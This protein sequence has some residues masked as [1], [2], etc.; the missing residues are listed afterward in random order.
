MSQVLVSYILRRIAKVADVNPSDINTS[1]LNG[2]IEL[3]NLSISEDVL[4][5][6]PIDVSIEVIPSVFIKLP[7]PTALSSPITVKVCG[8]HV[9]VRLHTL[10]MS[11]KKNTS[12]WEALAEEVLFPDDRCTAEKQVFSSFCSDSGGVYSTV[13]NEWMMEEGSSSSSEK[14]DGSES[15]IKSHAS[16]GSS[17]L[18]DLDLASCQSDVDSEKTASFTSLNEPSSTTLDEIPP[19]ES[20]GM[21]SYFK[22]KTY[23]LVERMMDR[24]FEISFENT[25]VEII[26]DERLSVACVGSIRSVSLVVEPSSM[27][28]GESMRPMQVTILDSLVTVFFGSQKATILRMEKLDANAALVVV[29][30]TRVPFRLNSSVTVNEVIV[31][32]D[33]GNVE[34]LAK[35]VE[36]MQN[37]LTIPAYCY[38]HLHF[39]KNPSWWPYTFSC[40]QSYLEDVRKRYNF[41]S[42]HIRFY[43]NSRRRYL[44]L[45]GECYQDGSIGRRR[46]DLEELE[47]D[48]RFPD[49]IYFLRQLLQ[50]KYGASNTPPNFTGIG[51]VRRRSLH[52]FN[53]CDPYSASNPDSVVSSLERDQKSSSSS[54][55]SRKV[56]LLTHIDVLATRVK[57]PHRSAV[58]VHQVH[59]ASRVDESSLEVGD[60][61]FESGDAPPSSA[62][63]SRTEEVL[64][65]VEM[66]TSDTNLV[67]KVKFQPMCIH[68][69]FSVLRTTIVPLLDIIVQ[70][71]VLVALD[72]MPFFRSHS[73]ETEKLAELPSI[74]AKGCG[75]VQLKNYFQAT[76]AHVDPSTL[77]THAT[78]KE[79]K[80]LK[81]LFIVIPSL[82]IKVENFLA[83]LRKASFTIQE[84]REQL[85][86]QFGIN[87][88]ELSIACDEP[89][90]SPLSSVPSPSEAFLLHPISVHMESDDSI[91]CSS[92][93]FEINS[94]VW[95]SILVIC[96]CYM[97]IVP[98]EFFLWRQKRK[99]SSTPT[100]V[101]NPSIVAPS[102]LELSG[103]STR[104]WKKPK[105]AQI[106]AIEELIVSFELLDVVARTGK[107]EIFPVVNDS[108]GVSD[109]KSQDFMNLSIISSEKK[110]LWKTENEGGY[111]WSVAV[112]GMNITI[113]HKEHFSIT[114]CIGDTF[115]PRYS[116]TTVNPTNLVTAGSGEHKQSGLPNHFSKGS[117]AKH[118]RLLFLP[119]HLFC[120]DIWDIVAI[121]N[122][123]AFSSPFQLASLPQLRVRTFGQDV[124][125]KVKEAVI[126]EGVTV[127][128]FWLAVHGE[129]LAYY[130]RPYIASSLWIQSR[131]VEIDLKKMGGFVLDPLILLA[132]H[133]DSVFSSGE[134]VTNRTYN[135]FYS[136]FSHAI[137]T[138]DVKDCPIILSDSAKL[139]ITLEHLPLPKEESVSDDSSYSHQK[140]MLNPL[141][142][143]ACN[144]TSDIDSPFQPFIIF[145]DIELLQQFFSMNPL[146][147]RLS[148][149]LK[150]PRAQVE[151]DI[152]GL[153]IEIPMTKLEVWNKKVLSKSVPLLNATLSKAEALVSVAVETEKSREADEYPVLRVRLQHIFFQDVL[154]NSVSISSR[155][156]GKRQS[157]SS[158]SNDRSRR[159]SIN[160]S[161]S[162]DDIAS[163]SCRK[164][165]A[166]S[167]VV[168]LHVEHPLQVYHHVVALGERLACV[169]LIFAHYT[170]IQSA[171]SHQ[172]FVLEETGDIF[173]DS[174]SEWNKVI[175][176]ESCTFRSSVTDR[177][178]VVVDGTVVLFR[179]CTFQHQGETFLRGSGP[180]SF[181]VCENCTD[182]I[183]VPNSRS[184]LSEV[185]SQRKLQVMLTKASLHIYLTDKTVFHA[186]NHVVDFTVT[187]KQAL[188]F[189]LLHFH[190][191]QAIITDDGVETI[192]SSE[193]TIKS[194]VSFK[195]KKKVLAMNLNLSFGEVTIPL[196]FHVFPQIA[197]ILAI[198]LNGPPPQRYVVPRPPSKDISK[199]PVNEWKVLLSLSV[200]PINIALRSGCVIAKLRLSNG[201]VWSILNAQ[202]EQKATLEGHFGFSHFSL[203]DFGL[204]SF[205]QITRVPL[206]FNVTGEA[207]DLCNASADVK[208]S[209]GEVVCT[210]NQ[211]R[212]LSTL[213]EHSAKLNTT[214]VRL[215]N[216]T[217]DRVE[218]G[219]EGST[220]N[221]V[222]E[223]GMI[224]EYQ[225]QNLPFGGYVDRVTRIGEAEVKNREP[226]F[227]PIAIYGL[228][229]AVSFATVKLELENIVDHVQ[230]KTIT[231]HFVEEIQIFTVFHVKNET[232]YCLRFAAMETSESCLESF[233]VQPYSLSCFPSSMMN[234][235]KVKMSVLWHDRESTK[236]SLWEQECLLEFISAGQFHHPLPAVKE[237]RFASEPPEPSASFYLST[238][239]ELSWKSA[240]FLFVT[241]TQPEIQSNFLFPIEL[242]IFRSS[243]KQLI[244]KET[245]NPG[246]SVHLYDINPSFP[247]EILVRVVV[248]NLIF[249]SQETL[250]LTEPISECRIRMKSV[251]SPPEQGA[252]DLLVVPFQKVGTRVRGWILKP[253]N[254]CYIEGRCNKNIRLVSVDGEP[255][256]TIGC[257]GI[258]QL[259]GSSG[260]LGVKGGY[261]PLKVPMQLKFED[262]ESSNPFEIT[263]GNEGNVVECSFNENIEGVVCVA[264]FRPVPCNFFT[265]MEILSP[266]IFKNEGIDDV[267]HMRHEVHQKGSDNCVFSHIVSLPGGSEAS[268][269][270]YA[271]AASGYINY[272]SFSREPA[273]DEFSHRIEANLASGTS[274]T[275]QL[276]CGVSTHRVVISK[277]GPYDPAVVAVGPPQRLA[278][279]LVNLTS[280]D[281]TEAPA[282][283]IRRCASPLFLLDRNETQYAEATGAWEQDILLLSKPGGVC[284]RIRSAE[285]SVQEVEPDLFMY[286]I[287]AEKATTIVACGWNLNNG[288]TLRKITRPH[289]TFIVSV[290]CSSTSFIVYH[291]ESPILQ[292]AFQGINSLITTSGSYSTQT[293][294]TGVSLST[295]HDK[296]VLYVVEPLEISISLRDT[297]ISS[298][299]ISIQS[300]HL[301]A[302]PAVIVISDYFLGKILPVLQIGGKYSKISFRD[303]WKKQQ[304]LGFSS[305][306]DSAVIPKRVYVENA[307]LS[308]IELEMSWDR[309]GGSSTALQEILPWWASA[310][311]SLHHASLSTP[312]VELHQVSRDSVALLANSI[313]SLY[314]KELVKE[315]PKLVGTVGLFKKNTSILNRIVCKIG[316]FLSNSS[317]DDQIPGDQAR[318]L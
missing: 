3:K 15:E 186:R 145:S 103:A 37:I 160:S 74:A 45:L 284:Y 275:G 172:S 49:V 67:A 255:L 20:G 27:M 155:E 152:S 173:F 180:S 267:I 6:I 104:C 174:G 148:A 272:F 52:S 42:S 298:T 164:I 137:I 151:I 62:K 292:I 107:I 214:F 69:S 65:K 96:K 127:Q 187:I 199:F 308:P 311:P 121:Q 112:V 282:L 35:C 61:A 176:V 41:N 270:Y 46:K 118:F 245:L 122:S 205:R 239:Y 313:R 102:L 80:K 154:E 265:S 314:L 26:G 277:C 158:S 106:I 189:F 128:E 58:V 262:T 175:V 295:R 92:A 261:V 110:S 233:N 263:G 202:K 94:H 68:V 55:A 2:T 222:V 243:A 247:Y 237:L 269:P 117:L 197:Q 18:D 56:V 14:D 294:L 241:P 252:F 21:F 303:Q 25:K 141:L 278:F 86:P 283:T 126:L 73:K 276:E 31:C 287:A 12:L 178:V 30:G 44:R 136:G 135:T 99:M 59:V 9:K 249:E 293:T 161:S 190:D 81:I 165:S 53:S 242:Q 36:P 39:R 51:A 231:D 78:P 143:S 19:L 29:K 114:L 203:L 288:E 264:L 208:V 91:H 258:P 85:H 217:G 7:T 105:M 280:A 227:G 218:F 60:V 83:V 177:C 149:A 195:P 274:W 171:I 125:V 163:F 191:G 196:L 40:I 212:L 97:T 246:D 77:A 90:R 71:N 66:G 88:E 235:K 142:F 75:T 273:V 229:G 250:S 224:K 184:T 109:N 259:P 300:F 116:E 144:L 13:K 82:S 170:L 253:S 232:K 211:I 285:D 93:R 89:P 100:L 43:C 139:W 317:E 244:R 131:I 299:A 215:I 54:Q 312:Q 289:P 22:R 260:S 150:I 304:L 140:K 10:L 129:P 281:F 271:L 47:A 87:V 72:A 48:I 307:T 146:K 147:L 162:V 84:N 64:M 279:Q 124:S 33:E 17:E 219:G 138:V 120:V 200:V 79:A 156:S 5:K 115:K 168:S 209:L 119:S 297:K 111:G 306:K 133:I 57:L 8:V 34:V 63:V 28:R 108:P 291:E 268:V 169:P 240:L 179:N 183:I 296:K 32:L 204:R 315:I 11:N 157:R 192:V 256:G 286:T 38:P 310:I 95:E 181:F 309:N 230:V 251:V 24:R 221:L 305:K 50:E 225:A 23:D 16:F 4:K 223:P 76:M 132:S 318:L 98:E 188:L 130:D 257:A 290:A 301:T 206:D 123:P 236:E 228:D 201:Y 182:N 159:S 210:S 193:V 101:G 216:H 254:L 248:G 70:H 302:T 113:G 1:L 198:S 226:F 194:E 207:S 166:Q 220:V 316:S 153:R 266:L 185:R 134:L 238:S 167:V 234:A 213:M